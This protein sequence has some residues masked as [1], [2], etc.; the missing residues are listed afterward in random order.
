VRRAGDR[1]RVTVQLSSA[2]D[3]FERWSHEYESRSADVFQVQD[4]LT[5]AIV[6]ALEPQLRGTAASAASGQQ[7]TADA[8]AYEH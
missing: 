8:R 4:S 3:G 6:A 2:A 7:G 5:R 1:L